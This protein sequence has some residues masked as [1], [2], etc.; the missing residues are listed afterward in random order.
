MKKPYPRS[1]RLQRRGQFLY[2]QGNGR[3]CHAR[4]CLLIFLP[5]KEPTSRI[6]ITVSKKIDKRAVVRNLIRRRIR[7]AM[8]DIRDRIR[9]QS[10]DLVIIARQSS[11]GASAQE[12]RIDLESALLKARL[13]P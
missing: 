11:N 4:H 13:I 12:L 6:G 2:V 5:N 8:R 7:E 3:K 9:P 1:A 10:V